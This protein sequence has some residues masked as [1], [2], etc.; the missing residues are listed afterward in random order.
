M[1]YMQVEFRNQRS[2]TLLENVMF[3]RSLLLSVKT[4]DFSACS[5]SDFCLVPFFEDCASL[6]GSAAA[7]FRVSPR[8]AHG[9]SGF[10]A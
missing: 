7:M 9:H 4:T 3:E 2:S 6:A 5:F 8:F 1:V 10:T